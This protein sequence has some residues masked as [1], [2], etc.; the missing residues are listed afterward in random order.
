[1]KFGESSARFSEV[2][3]ADLYSL[4]LAVGSF[5]FDKEALTSSPR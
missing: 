5:F 2:S 1:M 4:L 3:E